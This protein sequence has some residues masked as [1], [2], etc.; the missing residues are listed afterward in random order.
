MKNKIY[1]KKGDMGKT[2]LLGGKIV[3]KYDIRVEAYGTIDE[4]KS[5]LAL[6]NDYENEVSLCKKINSI[7]ETLFRI[8][9]LLACEDEIIYKRL[10]QI[11]EKDINFLEKEIDKMSKELPELKNFIIPGGN[12]ASSHCHVARCICRRAERVVIKLSEEVTIEKIIIKYIN[13]LSDYLFV[14]AR[15]LILK[16][17]E[18]EKEWQTNNKI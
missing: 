8:E 17:A 2:S 12:L 6:V 15:F 4:L 10:P 7:Q 18:N 9:A 1:T 11:A 5:Y 13:R 14:L 3:P 16:N